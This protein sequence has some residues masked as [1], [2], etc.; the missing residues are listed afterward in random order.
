MAEKEIDKETGVETTGHEWDGIKE[1]NNPLPRWWLH[2]FYISIIW[3]VIY[4]VLMPAWPGITGYT[5]G[6]RNHSERENVARAVDALALEREASMN[7]LLSVSNIEAIEADR[8]LRQFTM[9]AGMSLFG[10][11]CATCHGA[12]G[13]G[14]AG[15]PN[16]VDDDWLWGGKLS[17]IRQTLQYGIRSTHE[18]TRVSLMQGFGADGILSADEINDVADYVLSVS[19]RENEVSAQ[20]VTRGRVIF[21][22]Q[23]V[24]CHGSNAEGNKSLG[25]PNLTDAI[26]LFGGDKNTIVET[27]TY[28]RDG[29]MPAWTDR[30][31]QEQIV[32]L[33]VYVHSLGGGE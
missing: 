16:L 1:L 18:N 31:S 3:S 22:Q 10:D 20:A 30:L 29:V 32:A 24:V 7:K 25:A 5:K 8:E 19:G 27:I 2:T 13:Q 14:F 21:E 17:D 4:W 15:Y 11:N 9:A 33:S 28:G 12:G 23:C 26:W 6:V